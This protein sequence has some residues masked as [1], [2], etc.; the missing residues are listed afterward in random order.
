MIK[1]L[2]LIISLFIS[3]SSFANKKTEGFL[4]YNLPKKIVKKKE[5]EK[6]IPFKSLSPTTKKN[7]LVFNTRE[8]LARF[9]V[10]PTP[11]N[12]KKYIQW[13]DF[14]SKQTT[15][16]KRAFQQA[17]LENPEYDY[18]VTHP[19][20]NLGT[21]I[22]AKKKAIHEA[23]VINSLGR[24]HGLMFFYRGNNLYDA[25]QAR[26]VKSFGAR[27]HIKILPVSVDGVIAPEFENSKV[28][29]GQVKALKIKYFPA[30]MLFDSKHKKISPVSYGFVTQD[31]IA[32]Q[33]LMVTTNFKGD[34]L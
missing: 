21:K 32:H 24:T 3:I 22:T 16:G 14:W 7:I 10:E 30:L 23:I 25:K 11:E 33:I 27:F 18:N 26:I 4:W 13:Q 34:G 17:M 28:D 29:N 20:S 31:V 2:S 12:A 5:E 15:K 6:L 9:N 19:T 8:A 1:I